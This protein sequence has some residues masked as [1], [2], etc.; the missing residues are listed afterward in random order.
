MSEDQFLKG[1]R[2]Q[3]AACA[4]EFQDAQNKAILLQRRLEH[5]RGLIKTYEAPQEGM[6]ATPPMA[7]ILSRSPKATSRVEKGVQTRAA[8]EEI[9]TRAG[10]EP[11]PTKQLLA[12]LADMG[13]V[14]GGKN[15]VSNL[16]AMLSTSDGF[17]PVGR[18]GWVLASGVA[19][20]SEV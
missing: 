16:A 10:G 17:E 2:D 20:V 18:K 1:L 4:R 3:E 7:P 12:Q 15:P 19:T 13:I 5:I 8:C 6:A 9:I 11:V 14:V